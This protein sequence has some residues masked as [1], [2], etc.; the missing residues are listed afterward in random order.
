MSLF[1]EQLQG[2]LSL[3]PPQ[4]QAPGGVGERPATSVEG[5]PCRVPAPQHGPLQG[6]RVAI[7]P[8]LAPPALHWFILLS[9]RKKEK[10]KKKKKRRRSSSLTLRFL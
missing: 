3:R 9:K 5:A 2:N 4:P 6:A 10:G 8:R 7:P 1:K